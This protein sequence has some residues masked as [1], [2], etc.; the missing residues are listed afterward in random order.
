M[1]NIDKIKAEIQQMK[2]NLVTAELEA[3]AGDADAL[4]LRL[5]RIIG[6]AEYLK[7]LAYEAKT[8]PAVRS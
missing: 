5:R 7:G 4:D 6:Q 3:L 1:K 2:A 8:A